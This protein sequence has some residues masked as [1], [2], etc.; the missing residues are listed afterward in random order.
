[1]KSVLMTTVLAVCWAGAAHAQSYAT[2]G[3][4]GGVTTSI[5][6]A[7]RVQR[8]YSVVPEPASSS[9][10]EPA[11]SAP[12]YEAYEPTAFDE[13][14]YKTATEPSPFNGS[15]S[16]SGPVPV[17]IPTPTFPLQ[18]QQ[19]IRAYGEPVDVTP[20]DDFSQPLGSPQTFARVESQPSVDDAGFA[21]ETET[22]RLLLAL[23][24]TYARRVADLKSKHLA[25]RRSLLEGFEKDA[26]D[27]KKVI[28]LAERMRNALAEAD[29]AQ[30]ALLKIEESQFNA[31]T[32]Q[33]LDASPTRTQ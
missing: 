12:I 27:P 18:Q 17:A 2:Y 5:S 6:S 28:G 25:V 21:Q 26:A 10:F 13:S 22:S 15:Y 7:E 30:N 24:D 31:A 20:F 1:M 29:A 9:A 14:A 11:Y 4:P 23:E 16:A 3:E 19:V 33:V 8:T 32:L